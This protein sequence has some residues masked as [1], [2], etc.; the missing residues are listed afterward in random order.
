MTPRRSCLLL[1]A[2][3]F[4][5]SAC[6]AEASA[7]GKESAPPA[8]TGSVHRSVAPRVQVPQPQVDPREGALN[9]A[10]ETVVAES[11]SRVRE[12]SGGKAHAGNVNVAISVRELGPRPV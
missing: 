1:L 4:V 9:S 8:A 3:L 10:F 11:I 7:G 5:S 12:L 2:G 6:S